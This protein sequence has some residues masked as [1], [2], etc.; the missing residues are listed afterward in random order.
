MKQI[1]NFEKPAKLNEPSPTDSKIEDIEKRLTQMLDAR[2]LK[3]DVFRVEMEQILNDLI[4]EAINFESPD[5]ISS[6][7]SVQNSDNETK[8]RL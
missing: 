1:V 8:P 2:F 5:Q 3:Q 4:L 6:Q 7:K